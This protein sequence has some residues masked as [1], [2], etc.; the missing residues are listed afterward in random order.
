MINIYNDDYETIIQN[1]VNDNKFYGYDMLFINLLGLNDQ[2]LNDNNYVQKIYDILSLTSYI[3]KNGGN[4]III[5]N[6]NH[7][8]FRNY[9][10]LEL[11]WRYNRTIILKTIVNNNSLLPNEFTYILWYSDNFRDTDN[12]PTYNKLDNITDLW[13]DITKNNISEIYQRIIKMFTNDNENIFSVFNID[14]LLLKTCEENNRNLIGVK[15]I[16]I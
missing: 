12:E 14:E 7:K 15:E 16:K 13:I 2:L 1:I 11:L 4:I 5:C 9:I 6:N 8:I 10:D 3:I